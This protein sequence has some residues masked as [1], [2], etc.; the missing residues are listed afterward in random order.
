[1]DQ[2]WLAS[3]PRDDGAL[4]TAEQGL[5]LTALL[6]SA[7]IGRVRL[8]VWPLCLEFNEED[9]TEVGEISLRPEVRPQAA[10]AVEVKL[11]PGAALQAIHVLDMVDVATLGAP[12][13]FALATRPG[14]LVLPPSPGYAAAS[15]KYLREHGLEPE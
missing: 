1:M 14:R 3:L 15:A 9:V 4:T 13:P 6:V 10:I 5:E 11:R 2:E 7:P 12:L 8:L